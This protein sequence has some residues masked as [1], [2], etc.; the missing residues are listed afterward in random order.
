[1]KKLI[2]TALICAML[3]SLAACNKKQSEQTT[4]MISETTAETT[5]TAE[6]AIADTEVNIS[7][8]GGE[9]APAEADA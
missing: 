2:A 6:A 5:A 3:F 9:P 4:A 7:V 1:M 8:N